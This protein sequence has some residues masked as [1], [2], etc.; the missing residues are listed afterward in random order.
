MLMSP[1]PNPP[2]RQCTPGSVGGYCGGRC[3]RHR[4]R[5][6]RTECVSAGAAPRTRNRV[7]LSGIGR[8]E[9][10]TSGD[11]EIPRARNGRENPGPSKPRVRHEIAQPGGADADAAGWSWVCEAANLAR[12][13]L[14]QMERRLHVRRDKDSRQA[15]RTRRRDEVA[16][17]PTERLTFT[18]DRANIPSLLGAGRAPSEAEFPLPRS[19]RRSQHGL[20]PAQTVQVPV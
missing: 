7:R 3:R 9:G 13:V 10:Q 5:E 16:G 1:A 2:R 4:R 19:L 8:T 17:W 18:P 6:R 15:V 11:A 14:D 12:A 20:W